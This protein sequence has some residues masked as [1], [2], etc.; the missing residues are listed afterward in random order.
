MNRVNKTISKYV[1]FFNISSSATLKE[2][3]T[4]K[5]N[6]VLPRTL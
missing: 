5:C 6:G 4:A 1:I 3:F 2:T